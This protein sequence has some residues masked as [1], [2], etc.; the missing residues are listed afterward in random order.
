MTTTITRRGLIT[1][2]AGAGAGL[3][4]GSGL[5][6]CSSPRPASA[7]TADART[8]ALAAAVEN[9]LTDVY[10][11]ML[12]TLR[13]GKTG[14]VTPA[15]GQFLATARA[16]HAEHARTWNSLLR[17]AHKPEIAGVPLAG[18]AALLRQAAATSLTALATLA[19]SLE[20]Q[21]AR[22]HL[23]SLGSLSGAAGISAAAGIA[24]I[25]AMHAA[26]IDCIVGARPVPDDFLVVDGAAHASDLLV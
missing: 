14:S 2:A 24:P 23:A 1:A 12:A 22:T 26:V 3:A 20:I 13:A 17:A 15:F 5:S 6:A 21:A 25:E 9:Q 10:D 7:Y 16:H 18:H 4:L 11:T 19:T 8:I